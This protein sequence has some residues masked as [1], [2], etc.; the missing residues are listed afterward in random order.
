MSQ[1]AAASSASSASTSAGTA[2]TQASTA[3]TQAGIAT[4]K[5]GEAAAS[6][7]A[8][9]AIYDTFDDRYLGVKA[10]NPTLDNDGNALV[11]GAMYF[12]SVNKYTYIYDGAVW[13]NVFVTPATPPIALATEV[14]GT[15][16]VANGGTNATTVAGA[17]SNLHIGKRAADLA[18]A[19]TTNLGDIDGDY[20]HITGTT[21]IT[22]FG[23]TGAVEGMIK[24][25]K[26]DSA[27]TLTHSSNL[28]LNKASTDILTVGGDRM[29]V[30]YQG[31]S[32]WRV[33]Y[34]TKGDG[35]ALVGGSSV[36]TFAASGTWTKPTSGSM[37]LVQNW[38]GGGGGQNGLGG[39]G[40]GYSQLIIP[41]ANLP[42]S[43]SVT[44]GAGGSAGVVGGSTTF[45]TL[46]TAFGGG[47]AAGLTCGGGGGLY[48]AGGTGT[49]GTPDGGAGSAS[50]GVVGGN[51]TNG[52]G[53]GGG[54]NTT[55]GKAQYGGAGGSANTTVAISIN[56]GNGGTTNANATAPAGGGGG[57]S[58][59]ATGARGECR[60]TVW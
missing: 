6:Q 35:T 47:A 57:N 37:C 30:V 29:G 52:G 50:N 4:T 13:V 43:V 7:A 40:G 3:T 45:G 21:T 14:T 41:L 49:A 56:G 58:G 25:I 19:A 16:P 42:S 54:Y 24:H 28:L 48:A 55:G 44:I 34:Y 26:F 33:L 1:N 10:A 59:F 60:V 51:G 38:G 22:S 32:V 53:G 46:L 27:L 11:A 36:Q 15:L 23:T 39:G 12:N 2:T 18:S 9:A 20:L 31:S 5:A 8:T 17:R